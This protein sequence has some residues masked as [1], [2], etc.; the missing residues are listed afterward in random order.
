MPGRARGVLRT[1]A[2][3]RVEVF[4]KFRLVSGRVFLARAAGLA[5]ALDDFVLHIRD[6]HH[7]GEDVTL[8]FQI[9]PDQVGEDERPEIADV[10]EVVHRRPAAVHAD[11]FAGRVERRKFLHRTSQR[12]EKSQTHVANGAVA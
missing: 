11:L 9:A 2:A 6:V 1:A 4:E 5:D 10:R 8:E 7:V 12:V 3:E